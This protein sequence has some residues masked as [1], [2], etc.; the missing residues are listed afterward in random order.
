MP[1]YRRELSECVFRTNVTDRFG[2]V[3]GD[4]GNVTGHFGNVTE[5]TG[6]RDWRCA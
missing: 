1:L 3:T 6:R 4:F 2:I 5:R